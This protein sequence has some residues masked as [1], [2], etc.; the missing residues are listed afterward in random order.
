MPGDDGIGAEARI[1]A[2]AHQ[3]LGKQI[4]GILIAMAAVSHAAQVNRTDGI[5][6]NEKRRDEIPPMGM[7]A[8]A[9]NQ[10]QAGLAGFT[11]CQIVDGT[12]F[13]FDSPLAIRGLNRPDEP[14]RRLRDFLFHANQPLQPEKTAC[15]RVTGQWRGR[16][17]G[18]EKPCH[19]VL[20][21]DWGRWS[22]RQ[23]LNLRPPAPHAGALPNCATPRRYA[24]RHCFESRSLPRRGRNHT[25]IGCIWEAL[26]TKINCAETAALPRVQHAVPECA[27][28]ADRNRQRGW[29]VSGAPH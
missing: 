12:T 23:D 8:T 15:R 17:C 21:R 2:D 22:G 20:N 9:M 16:G 11:P 1:F 24:V 25:C 4:T 29:R 5:A 7:C 6:I 18:M 14:V 19:G 27:R 26:F 28:A 10:E 3:F 13:H